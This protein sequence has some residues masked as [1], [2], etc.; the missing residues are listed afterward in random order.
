MISMLKNWPGQVE[1]NGKLYDSIR[2]LHEIP[3]LGDIHIVLHTMAKTPEK[4]GGTKVDQ[5]TDTEKVYRITVKKYMTQKSTPEFDFMS[6]WNGDSPMP[7]RTMVGTI[8]K[9]TPGMYHMTLHGSGKKTCNCLRCGRKLD[10]PVSR[11][12]GIGPECMSKL[13]IVANVDEVDSIKEQL[14]D[15]I[16]SGFV[17]KS[18]ILEMEEVANEH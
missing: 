13:G 1:V 9:Q 10:N 4:T 5:G 6:K 2:D 17:I 15:V 16:W 12:Y 7:L 14:V 11:Y 18:S 8:D 3:V